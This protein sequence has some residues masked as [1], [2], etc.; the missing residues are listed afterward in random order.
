MGDKIPQTDHRSE[1]EREI[2]VY[3]GH[4]HRALAAEICA[5]LNIPLS[6]SVRKKFS[7][8]N[9]YVQLLESVRERDIFISQPLVKPVSDNLLELLLLLGEAVHVVV[10]LPHEA[11]EPKDVLLHVRGEEH[12]AVEVCLASLLEYSTEH[13]VQAY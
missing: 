1:E 11:V 13:R 6:P 3:S 4:G 8:D 2:C 7:N 10:R 5:H 12:T 9:M